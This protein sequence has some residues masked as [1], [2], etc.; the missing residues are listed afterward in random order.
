MID[1]FC[2]CSRF[3][4]RNGAPP[5]V[6]QLGVYDNLAPLASRDLARGLVMI[7]DSKSGGA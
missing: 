6:V 7:L 3:F 1:T 2:G 4:V 5:Y